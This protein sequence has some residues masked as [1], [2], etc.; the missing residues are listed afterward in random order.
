MS[1]DQH[2]IWQ[3]GLCFKMSLTVIITVNSNIEYHLI[4]YLVEKNAKG[5]QYKII[6]IEMSEV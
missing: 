6:L 1:G 3:G 5:I 4:S 2:S